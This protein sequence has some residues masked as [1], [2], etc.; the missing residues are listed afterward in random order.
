MIEVEHLNVHYGEEEVLHNLSFSMVSQ[1]TYAIIGASGCGKTTLLYTLAGLI[2][3]TSGSVAVFGQPL[4]GV[5]KNTGLIL[6][7]YGLLPWK[8]A[9]ENI[10][11]P[12]K[13]RGISKQQIDYKV[14]SIFDSLKIGPIQNKL[15]GELS[16]GQK[17]RVAIARTLALEPDLLLMDEPSSAVDSITKEHIQN[18]ILQ[19][20]KERRMTLIIVTHNIEEAVFLGQK[21]IIMGNGRIKHMME[22]PYFGL[23]NS[24]NQIEFYQMGLQLRKWLYEE[25]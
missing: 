4:Q 25:G 5:R 15:P 11:F 10:S 14:D 17:Q 8:T 24:R 21:V 6:Q 3:P 23:E 12:L 20:Y 9:K 2:K 7:D 1:S 22:N 13:S 16:G 18:L 19:I